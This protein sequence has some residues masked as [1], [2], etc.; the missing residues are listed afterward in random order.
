MLR[1]TS[2]K[3]YNNRIVR[4]QHQDYA[5]KT[6]RFPLF[7][8]LVLVL[9]F[10]MVA[11][12]QTLTIQFDDDNTIWP[13]W[14]NETYQDSQ[15]V[16]WNPNIKSGSL[17]INPTTNLLENI[18]VRFSGW[19]NTGLWNLL[20]P[21]D[22]FID[23]DDDGSWNYVFNF[24]DHTL[25]TNQIPFF[26]VLPSGNINAR[27][28]Y[29]INGTDLQIAGPGDDYLMSNWTNGR[30]LHPITFNPNATNINFSESPTSAYISGWRTDTITFH[31]LNIDLSGMGKIAIGWTQNCANDVLYQSMVVPEPGTLLLLGIGLAGLLVV[32]R[33]MTAHGA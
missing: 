19:M 11:P 17:N 22:L 9:F 31:N 5:M 32:C 24:W 7:T 10:W 25:N 2:P 33:R 27:F 14:D 13:G 3:K 26:G 20:R 29:R 18:I 21:G 16:I 1:L 6:L 12:A 23:L 4:P 30:N 15:D 28:L 8:L